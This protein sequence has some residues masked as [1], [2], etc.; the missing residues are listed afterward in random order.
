MTNPLNP[1]AQLFTTLIRNLQFPLSKP[2]Y[3]LLTLSIEASVE[4]IL[5]LPV[6]KL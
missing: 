5:N 4:F 2:Y 1:D 3:C 6:E